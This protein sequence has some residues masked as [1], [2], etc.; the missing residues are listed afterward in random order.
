MLTIQS[1]KSLFGKIA[2]TG[3]LFAL[4]AG[5]VWAE[6]IIDKP[7]PAFSGA[8]VDGSTINLS[9][10]KGK[11]VV[12]EWTNNECPYVKKH[13][14]LSSNI[15]G[16]QKAAAADDV[17]WLQII[18]SAPGK[19]GHVDAAGA[20]KL[21]EQRGA[22]PSNVILDEDGTIGK[23]YDAKTTP[24]MFVINVEGNLVYKGGIDSIS[25]TK[26]ED[27]PKATPHVK[28]ALEAVKAGDPV[29]NP[30]TAPYGCSIKY[31]S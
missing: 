24:H 17:V 2:A 28:E 15:P 9:D 23:L 31:A 6:A 7:A 22:A 11:I 4:V 10:L 14:D 27:I 16:L 21:N 19:Q 26:A 12:L 3:A 20:L 29:P 30:S 13:Y 5:P 25:S 18:S 1:T 8:A